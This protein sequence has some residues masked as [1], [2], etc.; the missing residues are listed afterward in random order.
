M[1]GF[2]FRYRLNGGRPTVRGFASL[3]S[4]ALIRGDIVNWEDGRVDFG[5]AGDAALLGVA[6][7]QL[8][9][10]ADGELQ[11]EVITDGDAVYAI[12]DPFSRSSG[13]LLDLEGLSGGQRVCRS[14]GS[15]LVV[16]VDSTADEQTLVRIRPE[17][18]HRHEEDGAGRLTG[19][20]LNAALA[21][22]V[23]RCHNEQLGRGPTRARA[24]YRDNV[25]VVMLQNALTK[26]E[27][28]LAASGKTDAVHQMRAA[29]QDAMRPDLVATVEELT[30]C[31]VEA[32]M[33]T[34]HL[35]PDYA[36][37]LFVLD[38]PVAGDTGEPG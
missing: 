6:L 26:A 29:F 2:E 20:E 19:G 1:P 31:K 33:S 5:I 35:D 9:P 14:T 34:N 18:H 8:P 12:D 7:D 13:D 4:A 37:E 23:V 10:S 15:Q 28:S 21:R 25:I 11:T 27:R 24:F 3:D 17:S 32:Y 36:A 16:V 30:G 22:A 38:R